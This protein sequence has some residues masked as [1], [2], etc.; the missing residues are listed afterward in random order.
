MH[1]IF[2]FWMNLRAIWFY[3]CIIANT[4]V[5]E[6]KLRILPVEDT[7]EL[8]SFIFVLLFNQPNN[9]LTHWST[10]FNPL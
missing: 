3:H 4:N 8:I 6:L 9:T 5:N 7:I 2:P 1:K 10:Y